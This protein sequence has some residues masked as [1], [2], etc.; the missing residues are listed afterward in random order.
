T[1]RAVR[2]AAN[3]A[4]QSRRSLYKQSMSL[5][6]FTI[7]IAVREVSAATTGACVLRCG[8]VVAGPVA[9]TLIWVGNTSAAPKPD[10]APQRQVPNAVKRLWSEYP[11]QPGRGGRTTKPT[12][13]RQ[14]APPLASRRR[15]V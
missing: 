5:T 13:D 11:L 1:C 7:D 12:L 15:D 6:R 10:P 2:R 9:A 8:S 14:G 4:P 3:S